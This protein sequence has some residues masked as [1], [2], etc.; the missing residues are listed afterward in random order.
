MQLRRTHSKPSPRKRTARA[1]EGTTRPA[2]S[3]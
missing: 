3:F 1:A 2:S